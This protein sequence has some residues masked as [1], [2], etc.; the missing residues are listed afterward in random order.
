MA[1]CQRPHDAETSKK[2]IRLDHLVPLPSH[3]DTKSGHVLKVAMA[4]IVSPRGTASS[5]QP[6]LDYL[7]RKMNMP[8]K[9]IQRR[10]YHEINE[11]I[12]HDS[13]DAAFIC[14]GAYRAGAAFMSVLVVPQIHG[15][16]TYRAVI[17]AKKKSDIRSMT[18]LRGKVFSFTDPMSNTGFAYPVSLLQKMGESPASFFSRTIFTYSHD[19][20]IYAVLDGMADAASVDE[21]VY[22]NTIK[23]EPGLAGK[24]VVIET[25]KC[26]PMPPVVVGRWHDKGQVQRL[27]RIFLGMHKD[28]AA[29][30]ILKKLDIDRFQPPLSSME[31]TL[32]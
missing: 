15:K 14:T 22:L 29:L 3:E 17:L 11:L 26:F 16:T 23:R 7:G 18:D 2:V 10:T 24:L 28:P 31:E 19:R 4:A 1:G 8:V 9:M 30:K 13:V 25:S 21:L 20:S 5:Y 12:Q 32:K 27:R 6:L